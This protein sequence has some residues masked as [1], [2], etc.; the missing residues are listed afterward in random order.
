MNEI[1]NAMISHM[2]Q[3]IENPALSDSIFVFDEVNM[4]V[5]FHQLNLTRGSNH[6]PLPDWLARKKA[7]INPNNSDVEC[8]KWAVIAAMRWE[9]TGKNPEQITKLKR[10]GN[11]F[12]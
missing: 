6:L 2:K 9:E 10:F 5:N 3:Q 8:F 12:D 11:D 4:D 7:I 1:V